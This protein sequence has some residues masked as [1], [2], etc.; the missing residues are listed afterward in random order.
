MHQAVAFRVALGERLRP[1]PT[2]R[3]RSRTPSSRLTA[4]WGGS[5]TAHPFR[6]WLLKIVANESRNRRDSPGRRAGLT[7]R[8]AGTATPGDVAP[9]PEAAVLSHGGAPEPD[10]LA[11]LDGP[12][13]Q[14][15]RP[16][17]PCWS[18]TSRRR[19]RRSG[20]RRGT[21]KSRTSRA[22]ERLRAGA[23]G[24]P[25]DRSSN[26]SS[27]GC[28]RGRLARAARCRGRC[29]RPA[30]PPA[31]RKTRHAQEA[32]ALR[33][34]LCSR[35]CSPFLP[36]P[37]ARTAVFDWLGIGGARIVRVDELPLARAAPRPGYPRRA[38]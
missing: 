9:S 2:P 38:R 19:L 16:P 7:L 31:G 37:P 8:I 1:L 5:V 20:L 35:R 26:V 36:C 24:G 11:R 32:C 28:G 17:A 22:L 12:R 15:P 25:G 33:S 18:S 27:A 6:P 4:R 10:A 3:R 21:V 23:G 30:S 34:P 13:P 29:R 14:R